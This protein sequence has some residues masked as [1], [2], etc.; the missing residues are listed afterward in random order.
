MTALASV[1]AALVAFATSVVGVVTGGNSL[2][3]VPALIALGMPSRQAVA[4]NMFAVTFLALSGWIRFARSGR[5]RWDVTAP[6]VGITLVTSWLGARLVSTLSEAAVRAIVAAS[7]VVMLG[8][9]ALRPRFGE[10][11]ARRVSRG[12]HLAGMA[13]AAA[14]GVYGGLFSGGYTTL[15]TFTCV[16]LLGTSLG[17]AV[18]LTKVVNFASSAIASAEFARQG[19]IDWRLA[20]PLAAAMIAGA[21]IGAGLAV[22]RGHRFL[23]AV[24]VTALAGLT[25]K[26]VVWDLVLRN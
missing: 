3:T 6:L 13:I 9:V 10:G 17:E 5:I 24:F 22:E 18:G 8:V 2:V 19:L 4:T 11:P 21:W 7:L 25:L 26:L 12:R 14:L 23:R 20:A 16:G 1:L 15:L